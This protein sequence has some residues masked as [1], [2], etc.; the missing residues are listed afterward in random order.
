MPFHHQYTIEYRIVNDKEQR[1]KCPWGV[2]FI[3]EIV[4]NFIEV[5]RYLMV[6]LKRYFIEVISKSL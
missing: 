2:S 4:N 1:V 3:S 5:S 6:L